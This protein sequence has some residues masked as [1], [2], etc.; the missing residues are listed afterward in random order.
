MKRDADPAALPFF[1]PARPGQ[2]FCLF[3]APSTRPARGALLYVHPFAEEMNKTRH[4]AY[5]QARAFAARGYGVLQIDLY[6]CG[7]SSGDFGEARWAIWKEDLA[8][9]CDWLAQ[10]VAAPLG[11]WGLRLGALLALDFASET[12][13]PLERLILWQPV[14]KGRAYLNQFLRLRLASDILSDDPRAGSTTA[15]LRRELDGATRIEVGGYEVAAELAAA[16]DGLDGALLAPRGPVH[17]F[18]LAPAAGVPPAAA[19]QAQLWRDAGV[20]LCL[21]AVPGAPF[22]ASAEIVECPA[23]LTATTALCAC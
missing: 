22:W 10:Q 12:A 5:L 1:L 19:H 16:I 20:A 17:W 14:F 15:A 11:L 23:L 4:L 8:L 2:R 6:G 13:L 7:D 18:E 21:H 9:A 3:H